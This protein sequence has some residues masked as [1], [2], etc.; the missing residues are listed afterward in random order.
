MRIYTG[1]IAPSARGGRREAER[2]AVRRL[3]ARAFGPDVEL[4]HDPNGRPYVPTMPGVY[5]SVA[6]CSDECLLAVSDIPV[7]VDIETAR[8]QLARIAAKFLTQ[9]EQA[10]GP[11]DIAALMRYWT[12]K[13]AVFKCA[14]IP[15]LVISEIEVRH[16][17][18]CRSMATCSPRPHGGG[19]SD[20]EYSK[21]SENF[22][23]AFPLVSP[24]K[25]VAVAVK[26]VI[27]SPT[28]V[29]FL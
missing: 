1:P 28:T 23:V 27:N 21:F 12:A 11:H 4:G 25:V 9:S 17:S 3:V 24:E 2:E 18:P 29:Q 22:S 6:H 10:V 26:E 14:G 13:E 8:P 15:A 19:V 5:V 20:D 16:E 7:G